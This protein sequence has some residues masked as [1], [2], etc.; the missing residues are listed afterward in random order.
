MSNFLR[1]QMPRASLRDT[2]LEF[3]TSEHYCPSE[4]HV[5]N[6]FEP[7]PCYTLAVYGKD[8]WD[9]RAGEAGSCKP[10]TSPAMGCEQDRGLH[11]A[12]DGWM[13]GRCGEAVSTCELWRK[14]PGMGWE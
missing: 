1:L 10:G 13:D 2:V 8:F 4:I 5:K 11:H 14:L 7:W 12:W 6:R 3:P 9:C